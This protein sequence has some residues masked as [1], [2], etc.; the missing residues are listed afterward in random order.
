MTLEQTPVL[1]VRNY[2][3]VDIIQGGMGVGVSD[4]ELARAVAAEGAMGVVSGTVIG[5][6]LARRLQNGDPDGSMRLA[7]AAFPDQAIAESI[8]E[9]YYLEGGRAP[10]QPY[11]KVPMFGSVDEQDA[12][13]LN[14][15]GGFVEV[16]LA[17]YIAAIRS[18][19][20]GPIG[21]NLMKKLERPTL[22]ALYG[23]ELAEV[24][25]VLVGAGI[26]YDIPKYLSALAIGEPVTMRLDVTKAEQRHEMTF[27]PSDYPLLANT[28]LKK[29]A[30]L[31]IVASNTLVK[32]LSQH[33]NPPDGFVIEG[34]VAGGHNALPRN[35]VEYG[36][37]D[38]VNLEAV[39]EFGRPFWLAGGYDSP[40]KLKEAQDR[41]ANGIQVGTAFLMSRDSALD[42]EVRER[43]IDLV[44]GDGIEV[45]TDMKAS[46]T[47]LPF[48]VAQLPG[49]LSDAKV[50]QE[51][52]RICDLGFLREAYVVI[53]EDGNAVVGKDGKEVI[54]YRCAAEPVANYVK[55]GGKLEDTLGRLCLCN[56]LMATIGLGQTRRGRPEPAVI[57]AGDI[58]SEVTQRLVG[59]YGRSFSAGEVVRYLRSSNSD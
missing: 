51:R 19:A 3:D 28:R 1:P 36:E 50:Y 25:T 35:K 42:T 2:E 32:A 39:A 6:V 20:P 43:I 37:R 26:P 24:D 15:A 47:G 11:K 38:Q 12:V 59:I 49:T 30:F 8:I 14:M 13:K 23:A 48:K 44:I 29:P 4:Y 56:G 21:I 5:P 33:D 22:S 54:D 52:N 53:G 16:W 41:G 57:T 40:E 46:P 45:V 55:K 9:T 58:L 10:D 31:A 17:K 27:D 7:L 34:P 18:E